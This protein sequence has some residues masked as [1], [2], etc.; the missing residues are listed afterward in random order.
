MED[1]IELV[2]SFFSNNRIFTGLL[3]KFFYVK[4]RCVSKVQQEGL[5]EKLVKRLTHAT[6]QSLPQTLVESPSGN[7]ESSSYS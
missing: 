3:R 4:K 7:A 2:V 1:S 5:H 6:S